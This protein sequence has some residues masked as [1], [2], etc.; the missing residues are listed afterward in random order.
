MYLNV[1]SIK[2]T[3]N[4]YIYI[5]TNIQISTVLNYFKSHHLVLQQINI[6]LYSFRFK[7]EN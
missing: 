4:M 1:N 5:H 7:V 3:I 2:L 6:I